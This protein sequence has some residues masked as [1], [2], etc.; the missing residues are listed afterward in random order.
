[1]KSI[2]NG[3]N[4]SNVGQTNAFAMKKWNTDKRDILNYRK[5]VASFKFDM[6]IYLKN[7]SCKVYQGNSVY[8]IDCAI[9]NKS[10]DL[11]HLAFT[12]DKLDGNK[13]VAL[14]KIISGICKL[15][16]M[17]IIK[18]KKNKW[19]VFISFGFKVEKKELNHNRTVG[20]NVGITNNLTMQIWDDDLK[21]WDRIAWKNCVLDGEK[22]IHYRQKI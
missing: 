13:K 4:T 8:E 22:L 12:I 17:Q 6:P 9:F 14:N 2:M 3:I 18:N 10:Q 1:M 11:K 21:E 15:G 16:V 19:C 5:S 7:T 20:V